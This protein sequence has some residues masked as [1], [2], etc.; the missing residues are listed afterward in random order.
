MSSKI[1]RKDDKR[2][3]LLR[4]L[5]RFLRQGWFFRVL[6]AVI[7]KLLDRMSD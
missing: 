5:K 7:W 2:Q 1:E 3:W 6:I 4:H